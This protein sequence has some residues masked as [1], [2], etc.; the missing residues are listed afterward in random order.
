MNIK[1]LLRLKRTWLLFAVVLYT[2]AGF[3]VA[4]RIIRNQALSQIQLNLGRDAEIE[5]VRLNPYTLSMAVEGFV[6]RPGTEHAGPGLV[7]RRGPTGQPARQCAGDARQYAQL[8][9]HDRSGGG[10][11]R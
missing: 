2:V 4:P 1:R 10:A 3:F 9:R 8:Q 6:L 7:D 11:R 5:K